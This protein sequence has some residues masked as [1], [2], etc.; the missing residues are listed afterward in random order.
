M[1][2]YLLL[3]KHILQPISSVLQREL[4]ACFYHDVFDTESLSTNGQGVD[5]IAQQ[6]ELIFAGGQ[7][8]FIGWEGVRGWFPY[9]LGVSH[10][11]YCSSSERFVPN[12]TLW[13]QLIGRRL[14]GFDVFGYSGTRPHLLL[15]SFEGIEVAIANCYFESDF[16]P[17]EPAGDDVWILLN[18]ESIQFFI[19]KLDLKKLEV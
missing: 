17:R 12:S 9:T 10:E 7:T 14:T 19:K 16:V 15:F 3:E 8:L 11:S 5:I 1:M 13:Q 6:V 18:S 2:S 4:S